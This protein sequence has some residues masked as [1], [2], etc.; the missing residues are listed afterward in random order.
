MTTSNIIETSVNSAGTTYFLEFTLVCALACVFFLIIIVGV[1]TKLVT[2]NRKSAKFFAPQKMKNPTSPFITPISSWT[3]TRDSTIPLS[4]RQPDYPLRTGN[5]P[6]AFGDSPAKSVPSSVGHSGAARD[7]VSMQN[8]RIIGGYLA[9]KKRERLDSKPSA[10]VLNNSN[11][12]YDFN[13]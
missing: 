13:I 10:L 11:C 12:P 7:R 4:V 1:V 5:P 6:A 8:M 9:R 3:P 2:K